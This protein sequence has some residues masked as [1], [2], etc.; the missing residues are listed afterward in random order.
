MTSPPI[1]A[2]WTLAHGYLAAG[3]AAARLRA[4]AA[5]TGVH[6]AKVSAL[7]GI[8]PPRLEAL[9]DRP[10]DAT[11]TVAELVALAMALDVEPAVL[12]AAEVP[13]DLGTID[14]V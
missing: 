4:I 8:K 3:H 10:G 12:L 2:G 5:E 13:V 9:L 11:L 6:R 1:R 7:T 14:T